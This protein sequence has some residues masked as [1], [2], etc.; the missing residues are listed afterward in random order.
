MLLRVLLEGASEITF[1]LLLISYEK[2]ILGL[3]SSATL[4]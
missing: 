2:N 3:C 4:S 1:N